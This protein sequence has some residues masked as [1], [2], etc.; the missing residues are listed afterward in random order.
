MTILNALAG[1]IK[2]FTKK[3]ISSA[4]LDA[5]ILL[6]YVLNHPREFIIA[7]PEKHLTPAEQKKCSSLISRRAKYE[8]IAYL[9]GAK[10]FYGLNIKVD[11]RVL[12]PRPE[13][14]L[15]VDE[16]IKIASARGAGGSKTAILDI[17]AGSGSI[18]L[19]LAKN[20]PKAR[21]AAL[22]ASADALNLAKNNAKAMR[23]EISFIKSDLLFGVKPGLI[24]GSILVANLPYLDK[25]E[26]KNFPLEIKRGLGHEPPSALYAKKRGIALYEKLFIQI[27]RLKIK[28]SHLV[29]EINSHNWRDFL[30]LAKKHFPDAAIEV[31]KDLAGRYRI[32]LIQF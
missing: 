9:T 17:G 23:L 7:H 22:E 8:P 21:I 6:A 18:A 14:E 20:L 29:A 11:K 26:I 2:K 12:I 28:P 10:E 25:S 13:T 31:K 3:H 24:A 1:A 4:E 5:E 32:L 16:V 27:G 30:A 19:A 15:L